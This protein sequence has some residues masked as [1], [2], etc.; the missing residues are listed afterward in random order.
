ERR[1]SAAA[2]AASLSGELEALRSRIMA[3]R[4]F[5]S[6]SEA[7]IEEADLAAESARKALESTNE[8]LRLLEKRA[9]GLVEAH[10]DIL[11]RCRATGGALQSSRRESSAL[12]RRLEDL[13]VEED[14]FYPA[15]VRFLSAATKLGRLPVS[16]SIAAEAFSCP[17]KIAPAL[18]AYLGGRQFWILVETL[19]EAGRCIDMLKERNAGRA[20]FLPLERSRPR[21]PARRFAL[22]ERGV[23]GWAAD[24]VTADPRWSPAVMHLL[25]DLFIVEEYSDGAIMVKQGATFPIATLEGEVFSP[26]GSV[27]GGR[28]RA[29]AGA[30]ERRNRIAAAEES[31]NVL[32]SRIEELSLAL[33][34]EEALERIRAGE[35]DESSRAIRDAGKGAEEHQAKL[36]AELARRGRLLESRRAGEEELLEWERLASEL[37]ARIDALSP[38]PEEESEDDDLATLPKEL[39]RMESEG[40]LLAERLSSVRA[41]CER[42]DEEIGRA[43][44]RRSALVEEEGASLAREKEEREKLSRRGKEQHALFIELG[45]IDAEMARTSE[46]GR[47]LA[48]RAE[49]VSTRAVKSAERAASFKV[50]SE[51]VERRIGEVA[52]DLSALI[53][54]NEESFT[55]D[56]SRAPRGEEGQAIASSVKRLERE[57]ASLGPIDWGALSEGD[58][59][60]GRV[61]YLNEQIAD[62]R[63]AIGELKGIIDE[64]DRY[65][66]TVF[67]EALGS[68][69]IRFDSLFRRL[70][71]GGEARLQLSAPRGAREDDEESQEAVS[72]EW[73]RG[74]EIVARPPGKHLQYLAQ[75]SGGE[76][77]LTAIA[78]LFA[79]MEAAGVPLAVLDEVYAALDESNLLRFGE[80]AREYARPG[81]MQ[82][83]AMTHRR[84]TMERADILYGVTLDEP[85]L[86]KVVGIKIDDWVEPKG[87]ALKAEPSAGRRS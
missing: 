26:G 12:E 18:E 19:E 82:L 41:L 61:S 42:S 87:G 3:G 17:P 45:E 71:G 51:A 72:A 46:L 84:A 65:V 34:K 16:M 8:R 13:R 27:S 47:S 9:P 77:T 36:D 73:D 37:E 2:S 23:V 52:S 10:N 15:P 48:A 70:F 62:V 33:E 5:L 30:I 4:S 14:S 21:S 81:G 38:V 50:R 68:I 25:G 39:A 60:D 54:A 22:P 55:Y 75:L 56:P 74:V 57:L 76:Q 83:V 32:R 35:R 86:S 6:A 79:A 28:S 59:L 7:D 20:T 67:S 11:A 24:L 29:A 49:A 1:E 40:A 63:A 80:L 31:L 43:M 58:A 64:T 69:N 53:D 44:E 85:G 66:A 78:Y